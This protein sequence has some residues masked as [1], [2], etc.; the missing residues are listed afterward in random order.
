MR[1]MNIYEDPFRCLGSAFRYR[2]QHLKTSVKLIRDV[3]ELGNFLIKLI[4]LL[5]PW[6]IL[7]NFMKVYKVLG[8]QITTVTI[9]DMFNI[10]VGCQEDNKRSH[11]LFNSLAQITVINSFSSRDESR[12]H[13]SHCYRSSTG[14]PQLCSF[15]GRFM[16]SSFKEGNAFDLSAVVCNA[17]APALWVMRT[18]KTFMGKRGKFYSSET[19]VF[20]INEHPK[21]RLLR[22]MM[23][24]TFH[25]E[26]IFEN[27][28]LSVRNGV[29]AN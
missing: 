27:V 22:T 17:W 4:K 15:A 14:T 8:L 24:K 6:K 20:L 23:R 19:F 12:T 7:H 13:G 9:P 18:M 2:F 10:H 25:L 5:S 1:I 28:F 3:S 29:E 21:K 26:L 16:T 11:N